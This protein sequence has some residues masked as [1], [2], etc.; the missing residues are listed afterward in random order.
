MAMNTKESDSR[1]HESLYLVSF[2]N[3]RAITAAIICSTIEMIR[4][5]SLTIIYN[6]E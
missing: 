3:L 2:I 4:A 6:I 5:M 1:I